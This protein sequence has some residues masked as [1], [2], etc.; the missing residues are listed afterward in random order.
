MT[1][2][3]AYPE[4][5]IIDAGE[6]YVSAAGTVYVTEQ[7]QVPKPINPSVTIAWKSVLFSIP[8][9]APYEAGEMAPSQFTALCAEDAL[10]HVWDDPAEDEAWRDL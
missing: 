9:P 8:V 10:R 2:T 6:Q 3:T 5:S 7:A 4:A 1:I